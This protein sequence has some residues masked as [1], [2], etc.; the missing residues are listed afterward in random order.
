MAGKV[1]AGV[2]SENMSPDV[3]R[4]WDRFSERIM[5]QKDA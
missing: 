1:W 5:P 4:G 3:I 2:I